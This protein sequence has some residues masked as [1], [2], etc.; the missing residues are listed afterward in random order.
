M[1]HFGLGKIALVAFMVLVAGAVLAT[2]VSAGTNVELLG[3]F[4]SWGY[5]V[6][7]TGEWIDDSGY[8]QFRARADVSEVHGY[9]T[10]GYM[11]IGL[12]VSGPGGY[13]NMIRVD[14][15]YRGSTGWIGT[16]GDSSQLRQE[17]DIESVLT[18]SGGGTSG[19]SIYTLT[20]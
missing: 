5:Y 3:S 14:N 19:S 15:T 4:D 7:S 10:T 11:Y 1:K 17:H 16:L 12:Y 6:A 9:D 13:G 8:D 20:P 18:A 2:P